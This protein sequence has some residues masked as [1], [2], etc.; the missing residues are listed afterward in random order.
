MDYIKNWRFWT[1]LLSGFGI[2]S[3]CKISKDE[4]GSLDQRPPAIVFKIV[5][6]I[7][8]ILLG[9]S[10]VNAISSIELDLMHG[11]CTILLTLWIVIF[12]CF[13]K[14]KIALYTISL[15][16]AILICCMSMHK[17]TYSKIVLI[18]VLAWLFIAFQLNWNII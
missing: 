14:K 8:Y 1:P 13:N 9:F 10:W 15:I 3:I 4:G 11:L 2:S 16:I 12:A 5:W 6:P 7:L 18:P 17:H